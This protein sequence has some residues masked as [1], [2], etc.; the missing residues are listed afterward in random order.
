MCG[1]SGIISLGDNLNDNDYLTVKRMSDSISH[2]GPD[3]QKIQK[4]EKIIIANNRLKIMDLNDRSSLPM[5]SGDGS[6]WICYNGEI[7]NFIELKDKYKLSEKYNFKGTSDTEVMIYLYKELGI[8][9]VNELS[10]MFAFCLVDLKRK[11]TWLVRD[12]FGIIPL[13]YRIKEN[14]I[15][16]ASEIKAFYE[17]SSL[18]KSLDYHSIYHFFTLAYIPGKNTPFKE[19]SEMRGGQLIE[20]D[21]EKN[22]YSLKKY[23]SVKY[24]IDH[25]I[26]EKDAAKTAYDL[27]KDSVRRNIQSD[28]PIGTTLSGGID[29]SAIT[30]LI[31]DLGKSKNFHTYS[32]K[33]GEK[34]F[35]ESKYQRLIADY[36]QTNHH[37]ILVN[38]E[39]VLNSIYTHMAHIDEPNGNGAAIPSFILA[40][41]AKK[42][43]SVLL[44][45]E[46]G[47]ETFSAY[48]IYGAY[49]A[50]NLY[51]KFA[52]KPLRKIIY[53]LVH[54]L[55]T[56][57]KKL[58]LDFQMKRFTEGAELHPASAHI[59]WRHVLTDDEKEDTILNRQGYEK[60]EK[61]MIDLFES[62]DY[63]DDFNKINFLDIEHFFIDDLLVK[64]DRM[65]LANAVESRFPFMD[66]IL[67][68]YMA[69]VPPNM[70]MKGITKRRYIEKLA[71]K[72]SVPKEILARGNFGLEMPH[73]IW[74]FDNLKPLLKKYLSEEMIKKT[75]YLS[76]EKVDKLLQMHFSRKKDYGRALW[77]IL[78]Y[79]MWHEMFIEKNNYKNYLVR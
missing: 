46:G 48:S 77:C 31:K 27:M 76:Y 69:K 2:R 47:D 57:Y 15:Y 30:C 21:N 56:S 64:N 14:K 65:F 63:S 32:L 42:E 11:K 20:I 18:E 68:E 67:F 66:R 39:D 35:D 36:C 55:P 54:K 6:V 8:S 58:S 50:K 60:T 59:Y 29:T 40:K 34:S 33:M 49:R 4:F 3:Q 78:M 26:T 62:L 71:M 5:S 10:G 16:F 52:P 24:P 72:N 25:S 73:S 61:V 74:F 41:E 43:V 37:E 38:Q 12:F 51:T 7:S 28:A 79:Q 70:R 13:F 22:T 53:N 17:I 23:Y 9:F 19:I 75:E 45:G 44:N 1:I